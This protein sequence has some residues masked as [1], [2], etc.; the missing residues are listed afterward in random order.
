MS[1]VTVGRDTSSPINS[2]DV[3]HGSGAHVPLIH[4]WPLDSRSWAPQRHPLLAAA[5]RMTSYECEASAGA[6][7]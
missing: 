6:A 2:H 3:D 1:I 7:A 5:F 4:G